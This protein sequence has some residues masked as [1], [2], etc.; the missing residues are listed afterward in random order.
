MN[1]NWILK[2]WGFTSMQDLLQSTLHIGSLKPMMVLSVTFGTLSSI[3]DKFLGLEPLVYLCF[4]IL[5][6]VEFITGI[7]ASIKEGKKIESKRLGRFIVKI[8]VYTLMIAIVNILNKSFDDRIVGKIYNFIYWVIIDFITLQLII[9][10]FENLS[11][12]GFQESSR[13]FNKI[14]KYLSKWFDVKK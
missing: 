8:V 2:D 5:L 1:K 6:I 12:L 10:V 7:S 13:V 3:T 4:L 14:N 11:R 9:S